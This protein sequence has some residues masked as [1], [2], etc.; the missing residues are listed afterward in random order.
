MQSKKEIL[1]KLKEIIKIT[2]NILTCQNGQ[3]DQKY[4]HSQL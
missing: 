3:N 1:E 2:Q 4:H